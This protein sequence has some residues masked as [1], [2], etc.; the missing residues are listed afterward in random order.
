VS[1]PVSLICQAIDPQAE[2]YRR[3]THLEQD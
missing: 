1:V 2:I 3:N